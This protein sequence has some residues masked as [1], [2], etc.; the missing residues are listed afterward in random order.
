VS[1]TSKPDV[2][3]EKNPAEQRSSSRFVRP[4][5]MRN[6]TSG[7]RDEERTSTW[8]EL[9]FDLCFVV[10]VAA[11]A[12]GLHHEPN[13]GGMLRFL[14][15][16]VP[17]WWSWMIFTWYATSFDNNDVPYRLT[18]LA[19][20]LSILGLAASVGRVGVDPAATV[21]FVSA[22][23]FMRLLVAA[24]FLRAGRYVP[25]A[26]RR[27][28]YIYAA[29]NVIGATIWL[30]SLLVP[31]PWRYAV[32]VLGLCVEL[33]CPI[34]AVMTLDNPRVTFHPRHIAERYGLFT[35]IVLGESVLAVAS[36]TSGTDW[37]P[38]AVLTAVVG[39][40]AAA[41]IWWLY[42][43]HVGSSG[44]ELGPRPAFYW[45]YGHFAV[46][47]GIAAFG[48]GV[49]LAIEA[50]APQVAFALAEGAPPSAAYGLG[51]R[52]VLAGGVVLFLLGIAFVDRIN[53]GTTN[54]RVLL[55]RLGAVAL[56]VVLTVLGPLLS[57]L[58]FTVTLSLIL[59]AL[60]AFESLGAD[61]QGGQSTD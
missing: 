23:A 37:A 44:I 43:D 38:S 39:F 52:T 13:V 40:V 28:V 35:L 2:V 5:V 14:G 31:A 19:A 21:S 24:L 55:A 54:D 59:F 36:G 51:A 29:G 22:Y 18:L 7:Q 16:F 9:F 11:L 3:S 48:V 50:A 8:L 4:Q 17:V 58:A 42:F 25:A 47:A 1:E 6:L 60:T 27:F 20:M 34:L 56:L 46:Y 32:W 26:M 45:G 33:L 10:A 53:E 15:L 30:S 57:P 12:S 41:C 49:Q 61:P